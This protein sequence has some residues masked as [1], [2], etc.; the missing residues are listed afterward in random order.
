[1]PN[2]RKDNSAMD[3][4]G[5]TKMSRNKCTFCGDPKPV[6]LGL[7]VNCYNRQHKTGSPEYKKK[8][9]GNTVRGRLADRREYYATHL[10][11]RDERDQ[12]ILDMI[13]LG[14]TYKAIASEFGISTQRVGNLINIMHKS[15]GE[16]K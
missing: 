8:P 4:E 3:P 5:N 11:P 2:I 15:K 7:C 16:T 9:K 14:Y 12:K 13:G 6:A 10:T 1:M